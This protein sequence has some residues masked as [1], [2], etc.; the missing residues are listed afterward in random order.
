MR[1]HWLDH[2]FSA[3]EHVGFPTDDFEDHLAK[4]AHRLKGDLGYAIDG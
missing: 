3:A 2:G 4:E 1:R